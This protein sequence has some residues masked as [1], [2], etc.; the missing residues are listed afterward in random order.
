MADQTI[1]DVR[2]KFPQYG[3][4]SD[5]QLAQGLHQKFYSDMPYEQFSQKIGLKAAAP[6]AP[7]VDPKGNFS[8]SVGAAAH[9]VAGAA[10]KIGTGILN[11]PHQFMSGAH[12]I[13]SRIYGNG[14]DTSAPLEAH[15]GQAG[16]DFDAGI[17]QMFPGTKNG[18][19]ISDEELRQ[20]DPSGKQPIEAL[21]AKYAP[22]GKKSTPELLEGTPGGDLAAG[23]MR[24]G[25]SALNTVPML[26]ATKIAL[27]AGGKLL[28]AALTPNATE[29]G[30][31]T[32][33]QSSIRAA[34]AGP[35]GTTQRILQNQPIAN[36][37]AANDI[38]HPTD[39]PMTPQSVQ[40]A[41]APA[42]AVYNRAA[43]ALP[44]MALSADKDTAAAISS[45]GSGGRISTGTPQSQ[46]MI[47]KLKSD[48]LNGN[49]VT[50][51]QTV[52]ELSG[53]RQDAYANLG[54]EDIDKRTLG[55]AQLDMANALEDHIQRNLPANAP[56]SLDQLKAARVLLAKNSTV[57][58]ALK[59]NDIDMGAL[60][61]IHGDNPGLMTDGLA[62]V[63]QF[64]AENPTVSSLAN[65]IPDTS[66]PNFANDL[67]DVSLTK[68]SSLLQ[69]ITGALSRRA[70]AGSAKGNMATAEAAFPPRGTADLA[71][72]P[73]TQ[74]LLP[75]PSPANP[76]TY[77][78]AGGGATTASTLADELGM[79][80]G[81]QA[82][83]PR[84]P[85]APRPGVEETAPEPRSMPEV[86]MQHPIRGG[87]SLQ[88][89]N[90]PAANAAGRRQDI[91]LADMLSGGVEQ[92]PAAGLSAGP[93]GIQHPG[94]IPY[95]LN[96]DFMSGGLSLADELAPTGREALG[97]VSK[98]RSQGVPEDIVTRTNAPTKLELGDTIE[99]PANK[100]Q[101][102]APKGPAEV[103]RGKGR[104]QRPT[105]K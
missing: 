48:L 29:G 52:R 24:V 82:A 19:D 64:A 101:K 31:V 17:G 43:N 26:G 66:R 88:S 69:P 55:K 74:K 5:E 23:A 85:G 59:G 16:K 63:G 21:R 33:N 7:P 76:P 36:R 79:S 102:P 96:H 56:V 1:A 78:N 86:E 10:D 87:L 77:V 11:I 103:Q 67:R 27:G 98:V 15:L 91:P 42:N 46:A 53:L 14:E 62:H 4:M 8:A 81:V 20:L 65:K 9:D 75:A 32:Q 49:P 50:G 39:K 6:P 38:A 84:H 47:S 13:L 70:I 72:I 35:S 3:D 73:N 45:A 95:T 90:A 57:A 37:I 104:T 41:R 94:G 80:P 12:N 25:S 92:R 71:P 2:A 61:R 40:D 89:E 44:D 58:G 97:D 93:M 60:G 28:D 100:F 105:E 54:A 22:E 34:A 51:D 83:G 99:A 30:L 68:P 18:L